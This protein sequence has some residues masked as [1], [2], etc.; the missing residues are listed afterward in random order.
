MD[1]FEKSLNRGIFLD[2][3]IQQIYNS[4]TFLFY[5]RNIYGNSTLEELWSKLSYFFGDLDYID[6]EVSQEDIEL[7]VRFSQNAPNSIENLKGLKLSEQI[8]LIKKFFEK[9]KDDPI[10]AISILEKQKVDKDIELDETT[11]LLLELS[12]RKEIVNDTKGK[13]YKIFG[14]E[15]T[16]ESPKKDDD[17]SWLF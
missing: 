17:I 9:F 11:S 1:I 3:N 2:K 6:K 14:V 10:V 13:V 8:L 16:P 4:I 7:L 15:T 5:M 12:V